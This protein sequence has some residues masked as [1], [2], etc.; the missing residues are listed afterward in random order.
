[1]DGAWV[2]SSALA[3]LCQR[4]S[5]QDFETRA[6]HKCVGTDRAEL[7]VAGCA[8]LD[9]ILSLWPAP[10]IRVADRGIREGML[11]ELMQAARPSQ[12]AKRPGGSP[13]PRQ[14]KANV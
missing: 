9:G 10:R 11:L 8:I 14:E 6:A 13:L 5:G 12:P 4:L 3:D 2:D 1:V 7:I